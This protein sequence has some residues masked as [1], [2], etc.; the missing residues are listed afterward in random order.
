MSWKGIGKKKWKFEK[1]FTGEGSSYITN[2]SRGWY[3]IYTFQ[4][5]E[6][7]ALEELKWSLHEGET[8]ALVLVDIGSFR[9]RPLDP[10]ALENIRKILAF[11]EENQRDVILPSGLRPGG[12][13]K[14]T[15]AWFF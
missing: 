3:E 5:E 12:K 6:K 10:A 9:E 14:R 2:P 1:E 13:G 15:G 7:A 11:F 4:A 8:L